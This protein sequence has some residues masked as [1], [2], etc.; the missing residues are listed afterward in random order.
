MIFRSDQVEPLRIKMDMEKD[1]CAKLIG[2]GPRTVDL[3]ESG[4]TKK[5][6]RV[7]REKLIKLHKKAFKG[8]AK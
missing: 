1:E 6:Q 8:E 7:P 3:W 4:K 2:V 5:M